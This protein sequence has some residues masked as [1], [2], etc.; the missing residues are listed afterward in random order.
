MFDVL[1]QKAIDYAKNR[2]IVLPDEYYHAMTARQRRQAVSIAGLARLAQISHIMNELNKVLENGGTFSDFQKQVGGDLPKHRLDN[3]FRTNIQMAYAQGRYAH[4]QINKKH[5]PYLMYDAINDSRT[6]H[7]HARLDGVIRHIDDPFWDKHTPPIDYRCRC[8]VLAL[9]EEEAKE[10]GITS[11][12]DLPQNIKTF[13]SSPK[14]YQNDLDR[15]IDDVPVPIGGNSKAWQELKNRIKQEQAQA[16]EIID[17]VQELY[18][19]MAKQ[20]PF[21]TQAMTDIT[22][23][24]G[25]SLAGLEFRLKSEHSLQRKV[26][27]SILDGAG[28]NEVL[29]STSDIV[30]YTAILDKDNFVAQYQAVVQELIKNG[31]KIVIVKNTWKQ[32]QPYKGINTFVEKDGVVFEMQ[33]HT[34]ESFE[35]K[36]G[37]LHRLYEIYRA[38]TTKL[39]QKS[40]LGL[41]MI[42]L[43]D[44]ISNPTDVET[45][46]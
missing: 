30:R 28:L 42:K 46:K 33:Y 20:E 2:K 34:Q 39:E 44:K 3:I 38:K 10:K 24:A 17:K 36:N 32:G 27:K 31:Y 5:R 43:S 26:E 18:A 1:F 45:I 29:R 7:D 14:D 25:V 13:G 19:A 15:L 22:Q 16:T 21:I 37:E 8:T 4:Q 23:K 35:L 40:K 9:T 41:Q 12:D 11:D 6:R